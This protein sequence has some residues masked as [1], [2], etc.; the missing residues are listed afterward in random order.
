M[1]YDQIIKGRYVSLRSMD[2]SDARFSLDIRQDKEKTKY[3]HPV[4][5][6]IDKQTAWIKRQM[7]TPGD[8]FFVAE[9]ADGDKVGTI[10]VY[11][12]EGNLGHLGR[13]LMV[14]N[15][16]QSF[17]ATMLAMKFA[18]EILGL[19]ELYGDVHVDNTA[20]I[21]ISGA[22]GFHFKEPVYEEELDR[23]V[24]YCTSY[25]SEFPEYEAKISQMI[26]RD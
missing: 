24:K 12:I 19:D 7:E 18:Y 21:H 6:D 5:N 13:L 10:G 17:E 4:D 1:I 2:E 15:P 11:G 16:F 23:W 8:Y 9:T 20:S 25:R 14:G 22:M 3:L 26:Y